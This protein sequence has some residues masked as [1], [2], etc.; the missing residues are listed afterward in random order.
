[1]DPGD[2]DVM[3]EKPRNPKESFFAGGAGKRAIFGGLLIGVLTIFAFWFGYFEHGYTP[4][5]K[6]VPVEVLEYARTM[7]FMVLVAS[8]LFFSLAF[9]NPLKS[10]FKIVIL[11]NRYLVGA[12]IIG[13]FLQLIVIGIPAMQK[14]FNLQNLDLYGWIMAIGLG[15]VPLL[16]N[17][18]INICLRFKKRKA[19]IKKELF[20]L[21]HECSFVVLLAVSTV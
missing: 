1:M 8:Q 16:M 9:R 13:L 3:K 12:I 10:V 19:S 7:A 5:N 2:P 14:A 20:P 6:S 21:L 15:L 4:F 17:E 18:V 11:S